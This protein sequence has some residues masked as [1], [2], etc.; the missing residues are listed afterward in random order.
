MKHLSSSAVP[1]H[2]QP[3]GADPR[4]LGDNSSSTPDTK[5]L[6]C[7]F[8]REWNPLTLE[9]VGGACG[10]PAVKIVVWGDGDWSPACEHHGLVALTES[11]RAR[12]V[13]VAPLPAVSL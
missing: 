10:R 2:S 1:T 12:V 9:P 11:A 4:D 5:G 13:T 8:R 7:E 3:D 6:S